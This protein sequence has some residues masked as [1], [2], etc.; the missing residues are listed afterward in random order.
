MYMESGHGTGYVRLKN[1]IWPESQQDFMSLLLLR[2]RS[3][4]SRAI[5]CR[6][7]RFSNSHWSRARLSFLISSL[8]FPFFF[9]FFLSFFFFF[10]LIQT[11]LSRLLAS[12]RTSFRNI[13][14]SSA[15]P[16]VYVYRCVWTK[17]TH[18][19]T[20]IR[21]WSFYLLDFVSPLSLPYRVLAPC[22][23]S[24]VQMSFRFHLSVS[25]REAM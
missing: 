14:S 2:S 20:K 7:R 9:F 6:V 16:S 4:L 17:T 25:F 11:F 15:L 1:T 3:S 21:I 23:L 22:C 13:S 12:L 8:R 10:S 5:R 19:T 18:R 24:S